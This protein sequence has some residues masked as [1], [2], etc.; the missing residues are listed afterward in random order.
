MIRR[1][2]VEASVLT[3]AWLCPQTYRALRAPLPPLEDAPPPPPC[4]AGW[5]RE[6]RSE[7]AEIHSAPTPAPAPHRPGLGSARC[8]GAARLLCSRI[9]ARPAGSLLSR[10]PA[11]AAARFF[12]VHRQ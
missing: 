10:A 5:S 8:A 4:R 12:N 6:E 11:A 7:S 2:R 1:E 9:A 3:G